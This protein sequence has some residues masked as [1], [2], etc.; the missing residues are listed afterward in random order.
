MKRRHRIS[1]HRKV[2]RLERAAIMVEAVIVFP[3]LIVVMMGLAG[4]QAYRV[5]QPKRDPG[6]GE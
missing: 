1:D 5:I 4:F 3:V 6:L 2:S